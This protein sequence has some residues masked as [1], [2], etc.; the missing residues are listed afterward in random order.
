MEIIENKKFPAFALAVSVNISHIGIAPGIDDDKTLRI[1]E[2]LKWVLADAP[3]ETVGSALRDINHILC[4]STG[5]TTLLEENADEVFNSKIP[6][7]REVLGRKIAGT[8]GETVETAIFEIDNIL[9][10]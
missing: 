2:V 7:I 3:D 6:G 8:S 9:R 5:K 1:R 4:R 10:S